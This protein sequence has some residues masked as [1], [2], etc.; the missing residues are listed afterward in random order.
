MKI[1]V[2]AEHIAKGSRMMCDTCPIALAIKAATGTVSVNVYTTFIESQWGA[3]E[4]TSATRD[5]LQRFDRWGPPAVFPFTFD[6]P[7]PE[8]AP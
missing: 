6:L 5:F 4:H 7:L 8:R 3:L 2:T 1:T